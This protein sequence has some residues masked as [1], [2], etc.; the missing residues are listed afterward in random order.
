MMRKL[1]HYFR[2]YQDAVKL[3]GRRE[4]L[5]RSYAFVR[6]RVRGRLA[7]LRRAGAVAVPLIAPATARNIALVESL[8]IARVSRNLVLIVSDTKIRQCLHYRIHQKIRYLDG[9]GIRSQH[10]LP[11]EFGRLDSLLPFC[12]SVIIY[13]TEVDAEYLTRLRDADVRVIFEID[14]LVVGSALVRRSGILREIPEKMGENLCALSDR[15]LATA[16]SADELIVSTPYLAKIFGRTDSGLSDKPCHVIPNFLESDCSAAPQP[17]RYTFAYTTPSGSIRTELQMLIAYLKSHD[18]VCNHP[19]SILVMGNHLAATELQQAGFRHG[20]IMTTPFSEYEAYLE[21]ISRAGAVL[22]PLARTAF[23]A[24]KTPI[25]VM[26]AAL[27]GTQA[28][29]SPVGAYDEIREALP[30]KMLGIEDEDWRGAGNYAET[31]L[32]MR[33]HNLRELQQAVNGI[34]GPE[35]ARETYRQVFV[36]RLAIAPVLPCES[37]PAEHHGGL[38]FRVTRHRA[39]E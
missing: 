26:D 24:A 36:D 21:Q 17:V 37:D 9:I 27:A 25:R 39:A 33:N 30:T 35:T 18:L 28:V 31:T 38:D 14:D 23:N 34:F 2:V 11:T 5:R 29:F 12:H 3:Q 19:W 13:R 7:R 32:E 8:P 4:A 1:R 6:A 15:F 10:I 16:Q 20:H 22:I